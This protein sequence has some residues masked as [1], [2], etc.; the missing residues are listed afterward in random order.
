VVPLLRLL[1]VV[2]LAVMLGLPAVLEAQSSLFGVRGLGIPGRPLTPR[3][4]ATGGS[5]G[6]FDGESDLNPAAL[7]TLRGVSAG[8]VLA[9]SWRRWEAPLGDATLRDSRFPLLTIAGPVPGTRLALGVAVGSYA[10][11]D[12][13]LATSDTAE[14]RGVPVA[15][16]DTLSSLGGLSEIRLAAGYTL[17]ARTAVGAAVYW[18]TGSSRLDVRRSFSDSSYQS[19]GQSAE[20]SYLGVGAALGLTHQLSRNIRLAALVRSDHKA[21]VDRDSTRVYDV[22]LPYTFGLGIQVRASRRLSAAVTGIYR[23]WSGA[24][25]DLLAQ[26]GV[27]ARN[28]MEVALGGEFIRN[29][30]RPGALPIRLGVR[31]SDLPFPVVTGHR[32]REY[33]VSAGTGAR[34]AQD[35]AGIDFSVEQAWRSEGSPYKERAFTVILGL[36]IRPYGLNRAEP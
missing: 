26:G 4:R 19:F 21:K 2:V 25:S 10:D 12:F 29:L 1:R 20:L 22:D 36:S 30:R 13:R 17:S 8:F 7:T 31:Y 27:G 15:V 6:L 16:N 28:T 18:I 5:F 32:P 9:P 11:R 33:S 23:T 35:R 14:L 34:F 3:S 24:N